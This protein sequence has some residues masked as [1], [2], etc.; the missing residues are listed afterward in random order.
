MDESERRALEKDILG[1]L[2]AAIRDLTKMRA[3]EGRRLAAVLKDQLENIGSLC[4]VAGQAAESQ[5]ENLKQ[6]FS[7]QVS[8][9]INAEPA[10]SEERLMQEVAV[11]ITRADVREELDR[12]EAHIAA[13][14]EHLSGGGAIGRKLDFLCQEFTREANTICSK[15]SEIELSRVG[16]ELKSM[17]EQFREQVQNIE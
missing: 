14:S 2:K 4:T 16:L 17:V 11:L 10:L 1:G 7:A 5:P 9:L 8:E 13:S 15:A 3:G 6:R 12:L